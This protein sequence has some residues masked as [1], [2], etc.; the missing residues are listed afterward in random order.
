[1]KKVLR[2]LV[3]YLIIPFSSQEQ[4]Y[5]P[6][7]DSNCIWNE[8]LTDM[9][10]YSIDN[11]QYGIYGD[12]IFNSTIYN[13]IYL[14][15]DT[16]FP[17]ELG[18]YCAAIR[19]DNQKKIYVIDCQ[20]CFQPINTG[21][22]VILYDFSK[23]VG[24]T[25][26]VGIDGSGPIDYYIIDYVDSTLIDGTYRRT[27]HFVNYDYIEY[28]IEGIGSTR[29]L[30]SPITPETTGSL[31]WELICF[32]Q[33]S[34]VKYLNPSY[35]NCFPIL[36]GISESNGQSFQV[37]IAPNPVVGSSVLDL[38]KI[39]QEFINFSVYNVLGI[40]LTQYTLIHQS[41]VEISINDYPPGIYLF[42]LES[43]NHHIISNK[44]IIAN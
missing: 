2:F 14:L 6:F 8:V 40:K 30:F 32:N 7:P 15:N 13:K 16:V 36:T 37:Q 19:E 28:W 34:I 26:F 27:F 21:E 20:C 3:L 41:K 38:N 11:Y 42:L 24:D 22:E 23:N 33:N 9:Q 43:K 18:S 10:P 5:F 12:T 1:M 4:I 29:G 25:V 39:N 17:L 44:F 35:S 31:K